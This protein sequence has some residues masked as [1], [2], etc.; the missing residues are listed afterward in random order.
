M[1]ENENVSTETKTFIRFFVVD[2]LQCEIKVFV[3]A[4]VCVHVAPLTLIFLQAV[5]WFLCHFFVTVLLNIHLK[6]YKK[7][8][9]GNALAM[10]A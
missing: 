7:E 5:L 2:V 8:M 9:Y 4:T 10:R 3:A 6:L 1:Y